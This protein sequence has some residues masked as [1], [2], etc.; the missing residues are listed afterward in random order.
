MLNTI[1]AT[2]DIALS[3]IV[4]APLDYIMFVDVYQEFH[5]KEIRVIIG[6]MQVPIEHEGNLEIREDFLE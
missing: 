5:S 3:R 1:L 6:L 4:I 2:E